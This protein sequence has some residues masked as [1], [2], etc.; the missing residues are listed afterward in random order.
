MSPSATVPKSSPPHALRAWSLEDRLLL[1]QLAAAEEA[2][3]GTEPATTRLELD[4]RAIREAGAKNRGERMAVWYGRRRER[5]SP[6]E[7]AAAMRMAAAGT[8]VGWG[9]FVLGLVLGI[10]VAG[11][12][13]GALGALQVDRPAINAPAFLVIALGPQLVSLLV[14][15]G[16]LW[17]VG[18]TASSGGGP[19]PWLWNR[20]LARL[21]AAAGAG[22]S[23]RGGSDLPG[24]LRRVG[25]QLS[26]G[27][28]LGYAIGI[29]LG[30]LFAM[31]LWTH[32]F[33]WGSTFF[34]DRPEVVHRVV[35]VV[36]T[37]WSWFAGEGV[38]F[39]SRQTIEQSVETLGPE[40]SGAGAGWPGFVLGCLAVYGVL[41]RLL[42]ALATGLAAR[43]AVRRPDFSQPL[44][45]RLDAA[46]AGTSGPWRGPGERTAPPA[47]SAGSAQPCP[48]LPAMPSPL[49]ALIVPDELADGV[50]RV[51]SIASLR[52]LR[53][54]DCPDALLPPGGVLF[55]QEAFMPPT[56]EVL[57]RIEG[58]GARLGEDRQLF[59]ALLG[60]PNSAGDRTSATEREI[61]V[62][63]AMLAKTN[64]G[65][66][67]ICL[68]PSGGGAG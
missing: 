61:E 33:V 24:L 58:W 62:W 22:D 49:V 19:G 60:K 44:Y 57:R 21:G 9:L 8:A 17:R 35:E 52:Q 18:R 56:L 25:M 11:L 32:G 38:G 2:G 23:T 39:P 27:L 26:Q 68:L 54:G 7:R 1:A 12:A 67:G 40:E 55:V 36:A 66:A 10:S 41:P 20:L 31:L 13:F 65:P 14:S 53:P 45:A 16:I 63:T 15:L 6:E 3:T 5:A 28:P 48:L 37:P 42:L 4:R 51:E 47:A 50:S 30:A 46:L 64:P 29:L 34:R 43:R 59:V